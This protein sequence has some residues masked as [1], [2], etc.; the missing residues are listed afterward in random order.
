M[1]ATEKSTSPPPDLARIRTDL[2]NERTMLAYSR[3]AL[4]LMA[5]GVSLI[6]FI[7]D[8]SRMILLG[9]ACV[10]VGLSVL[11]LGIQRYASLR[12]RLD[13]GSSQ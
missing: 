10:I 13:E 8:G 2:A 11:L 6:Q 3:T 5:T 12:R 1:A 9:W 4:M 7:G